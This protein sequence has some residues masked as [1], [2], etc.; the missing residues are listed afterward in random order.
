MITQ[1]IYIIMGRGRRLSLVEQGQI[2]V[3]HRL[4]KSA[5]FIAK[6]LRRS[7]T[8]VQAYLRSPMLYG[9]KKSSGRPSAL[10]PREKRELVRTASNSM[11]SANDLK[12]QLGLAASRW[13]IRRTIHASPHIVR[14]KMMR[15]PTLTPAHKQAR[16]DFGRNNMATDWSKVRFWEGFEGCLGDVS[17]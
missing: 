13:T 5:N 11:K 14:Q 1:I 15:A 2:D 17:S 10:S 6:Q 9:K 8:V 16:L 12:E 3:L 4:R 7:R